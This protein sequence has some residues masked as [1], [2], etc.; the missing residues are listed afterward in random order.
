MEKRC[1][2]VR[3]LQSFSEAGSNRLKRCRKN[4]AGSCLTFL[5]RER[6]ADLSRQE[7]DAS[8]PRAKFG[9]C[10]IVR[11]AHRRPRVHRLLQWQL[12]DVRWGRQQAPGGPRGRQRANDRAR[13]LPDRSSRGPATRRRRGSTPSQSASLVFMLLKI[14]MFRLSHERVVDRDRTQH[15]ARESS[16]ISRK[17]CRQSAGGSQ[18]RQPTACNLPGPRRVVVPR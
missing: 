11:S 3:A 15:C 4:F 2:P 16:Q 8:R 7:R 9:A 17:H 18:G 13:A 10:V 6:G 5:R 14:V 1:T 12:A